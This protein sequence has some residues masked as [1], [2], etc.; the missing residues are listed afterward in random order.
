MADMRRAEQPGHRASIYVCANALLRDGISLWDAIRLA[1]EAGADGF[2]LRR[3]LLPAVLTQDEI[4]RARAAL[5]EMP[6]P[7]FYSTPQPMF[8]RGSFEREQVVCAL[9][10]ARALGCRAVKLAPGDTL[11]PDDAAF[12]ALRATTAA[13]DA[14]GASAAPL[15]VLL[16]NDQ[17]AVSGDIEAWAR[18]FERAT[19]SRCPLGMTFDIGNWTCLAINPAQAARTLGRY[20]AYVHVKAVRRTSDAW[21]SVPFRPAPAQHPALAYLPES[22]PRAVE[23]PVPA[24]GNDTLRERLAEYITALRDGAFDT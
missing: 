7:P 18:L 4:Q 6:L 24:S 10:E 3:E 2:E 11:R 19:A 21:V 22:V 9:A 15:L 8:L 1:R 12:D 17:T 13:E 20:V 23:F 16:E 14:S 5:A